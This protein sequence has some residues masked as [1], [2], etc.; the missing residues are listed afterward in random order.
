MTG[1][2]S[3][4]E[5]RLVQ[6]FL[7]LLLGLIDVT[8]QA[9][10]DGIRLGES[11]RPSGMRV[12]A[13]GAVALRA[14]MLKFRFLN[15][16]G[17]V[18]VTSDTN[19]PDL[20]L[21]QHDFSVLRSFVADFAKLFAEGRMHEGL[22]QLGL[23][24]LMRI[25]ARH[26][27][28]LGEGLP[29]VCLHQVFIVSIVAIETECRRR[30]RQMK[31]NLWIRLVAR[32]VR[33]VAG[34][35]TQIESF[36]SASALG[37]IEAGLVTIEAKILVGRGAGR[38]L[39]QVVRFSRR[40]RVVAG[41]TIARRLIVNMAAGSAFFV[42]VACEAKL[43]RSGGEQ[44][45]ASDVFGDTHFVAAQAVLFGGRVRVLIFRL[46]LVAS[47]AGGCCDIRIKRSRMLL[48]HGG[49]G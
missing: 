41:K 42:A 33:D 40:M 46:I 34:I 29:R 36:V 26:A 39:Q 14:R 38:S 2:A 30:F 3:L 6:D 20:R 11:R 28:G 49:D 43:G 13:I 21:R 17:L 24:G 16:V 31:C 18:R 7:V 4:S 47:N 10:V 22:H 32:L 12:V 8:I 35:A 19:V 25:V 5:G 1:R 45:Y 15:F 48:C 23:G 27:V 44:L 37:R 9:D